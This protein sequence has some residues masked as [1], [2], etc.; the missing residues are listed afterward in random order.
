MAEFPI[1]FGTALRA[2][3]VNACGMP[4]AGSANRLVTKG[5]VSF[6]ISA[7]MKAAND[8]EQL[9][10]EAKVCVVDRTPP[11]RKY[12]HI[13][14]EACGVNTELISLLSGWPQVLDWADEA[15]GYRDAKD[16]TSDY[17]VALE[18]WT[19]GRAEEDCPLPDTDAIFSAG[20]SGKKYGYFLIGGKEFSVG[21]INI[22]GDVATLTSSGISIPMTQWGRGPYNV[23]GLDGSNTP[24]RLLTPMGVDQHYHWE[25]TPIA[26]PPVTDGAVPLA[27]SSIFTP[28]NYY[29]GAAGGVPG[30]DVA[31]D[32]P[33]TSGS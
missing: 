20:G 33:G 10:A 27:V 9:N 19:G 17:G 23:V 14:I 4:V 25:R 30:I 32:Q 1:L 18:V 6:K 7:E 24:G 31:P 13:D 22:S 2:T 11:Q 26:P 29:F 8:I 3:L 28:P 12:Y 5:F 16:V 15:V 21:D